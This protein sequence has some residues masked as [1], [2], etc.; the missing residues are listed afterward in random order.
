MI[1]KKLI[2]VAVTDGPISLSHPIALN[3]VMPVFP[4]KPSILLRLLISPALLNTMPKKF[5]ST[6]RGIST[7]L[8]RRGII[9]F[10]Q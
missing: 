1:T 4:S 10:P 3:W 7:P 9:I 6:N 2:R 5:L 8:A